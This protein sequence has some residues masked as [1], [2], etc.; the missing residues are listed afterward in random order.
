MFCACAGCSN[1]SA[2]FAGD[3]SQRGAGGKRVFETSVIIYGADLIALQQFTFESAGKGRQL[4]MCWI[5]N[6]V[7]GLA[8]DEGKFENL[9]AGFAL[10]SGFDLIMD[11]GRSADHDTTA[12]G[13][14]LNMG[15]AGRWMDGKKRA[16]LLQKR[17]R[18]G[19]L[20][21]KIGFNGGNQRKSPLYAFVYSI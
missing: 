20:A 10:Q 11:V 17:R 6:V 1:D 16:G 19:K 18:A 7:D 15:S 9:I 14:H 8:I 12:V 2:V 21:G 3:K 4:K 5:G 13:Q